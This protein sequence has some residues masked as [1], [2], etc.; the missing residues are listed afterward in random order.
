MNRKIVAWAVVLVLAFG[1]FTHP[2]TAG[3]WAHEGWG[4]IGSARTNLSHFVDS[5]KG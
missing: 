5:A 1:A 4:A 2:A 3:R